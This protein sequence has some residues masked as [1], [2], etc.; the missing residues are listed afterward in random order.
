MSLYLRTLLD[1]RKEKT[2][3]Y[4]VRI[5]HAGYDREPLTFPTAISLAEYLSS[6]ARSR[7][8]NGRVLFTFKLIKD[9]DDGR[10]LAE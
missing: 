2:E 7:E 8:F 6:I 5:E 10:I 1:Y 4:Q 9:E 3:M